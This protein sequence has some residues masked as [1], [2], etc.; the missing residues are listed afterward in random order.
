MGEEILSQ[1]PR[2]F[3]WAVR[4]AER[5]PP[6]TR[7]L[8]FRGMWFAMGLALW[9]L[10]FIHFLPAD[11]PFYKYPVSLAVS[12]VVW[13]MYSAIILFSFFYIRRMRENLKH[14]HKKTSQ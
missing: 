10:L 4:R 5:M 9:L 11:A 1:P 14:N 7:V 6:R 13:T 12:F 2:L 8:V 3:L